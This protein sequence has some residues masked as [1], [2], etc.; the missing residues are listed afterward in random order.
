MLSSVGVHVTT[1][2][3]EVS[4]SMLAPLGSGRS[5]CGRSGILSVRSNPG[6][7]PPGADT[8][9]ESPGFHFAPV[10]DCG[11]YNPLASGLI[12]IPPPS[13]APTLT[14]PTVAP[15][16]PPFPYFED[17]QSINSQ[18][19]AGGGQ[20]P[21]TSDPTTPSAARLPG[22]LGFGSGVSA[23]ARRGCRAKRGRGGA[24]NVVNQVPLSRLR[25]TA[26]LRTGSEPC[27]AFLPQSRILHVQSVRSGS[28]RLTH[29]SADICNRQRNFLKRNVRWCA[30]SQRR[31]AAQVEPESPR[32]G[33]SLRSPAKG[34][35]DGT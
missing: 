20:I 1:N 31:L 9:T 6:N 18:A 23:G 15:V 4:T 28:G 25:G 19:A 22:I 16:K 11:G 27:T 29:F 30:I 13:A 12:T 24:P 17:R 33:V 3:A 26:A 34:L 14:A 7:C 35:S 10:P 8:G 21:I 5:H 2:G 32:I